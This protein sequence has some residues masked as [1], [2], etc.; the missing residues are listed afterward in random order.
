MNDYVEPS[1][2]EDIRREIADLTDLF[3]RRLLDD[4][5]KNALYETLQE[6]VKASQDLLR[7]RAFESLFREA[8]F[9]VDR[10]QTEPCTQQLVKSAVDELLEVFARRTLHPVA[11]GG[12]F[13]PRVHEA[14]ETI[15]ANEHLPAGSITMVHRAGYTLDGRLLRPAQV[16]VA[17]P[18]TTTTMT[19]TQV[20][21]AK[22]T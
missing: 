18:G 9:A 10:L 13:D 4:K 17:V 2:L 8:L 1:T 16:T 11:D 20:V 21:D 15:E 3:R 7:Y 5:A 12:T 6:Q 19:E 14:V 22:P